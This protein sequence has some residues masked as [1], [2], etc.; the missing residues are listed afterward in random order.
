[1]SEGKGRVDQLVISTQFAYCGEDMF[2]PC[3]LIF[4]DFVV[5]GQLL[6]SVSQIYLFQKGIY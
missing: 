4:T 2:G 5:I 1:M 3:C 6:V